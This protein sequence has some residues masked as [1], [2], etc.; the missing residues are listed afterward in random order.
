MKTSFNRFSTLIRINFFFSS[1]VK[2]T[3][4]ISTKEEETNN[5]FF[6]FWRV[7][8]HDVKVYKSSCYRSLLLDLCLDTLKLCFQSSVIILTDVWML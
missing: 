3:F 7:I 4:S 6:K 8:E 2:D 1:N 5:L